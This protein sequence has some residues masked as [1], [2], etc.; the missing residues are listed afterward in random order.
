MEDN[1]ENQPGR[2][3]SAAKK[4]Q[5]TLGIVAFLGIMAVTIVLALLDHP[6]FAARVFALLLGCVGVVRA[7]YR[8][9][10]VWFGAR[11]WWFD[12][13]VLVAMAAAIAY[14]SFYGGRAMPSLT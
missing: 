10:P 6:V 3:E 14:L 12:S 11:S 2:V 13:T 1:R 9:Q 8:N 4:L 7:V 5:R